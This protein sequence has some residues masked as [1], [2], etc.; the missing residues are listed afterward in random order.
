MGFFD[1][2]GKINPIKGAILGGGGKSHRPGKKWI[3]KQENRAR[4]EELTA[5][6]KDYGLIP[7]RLKENYT[8]AAIKAGTYANTPEF[9]Q[10]L[11]SEVQAGARGARF[12]AEARINSLRKAMGNEEVWKPEE[13]GQTAGNMTKDQLV[14]DN[15]PDKPVVDDA[16]APVAT[17]GPEAPAPTRVSKTNLSTAFNSRL[18]A[19]RNR[20]G[21][22][23]PAR[24]TSIKL[25]P[26]QS[27]E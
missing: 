25:N 18:S 13:S 24:Q 8:N 19:L 14:D 6:E 16:P 22:R 12:E 2:I 27:I 4:Q 21:S 10:G 5:A 7:D 15:V 23:T 1:V 9:A 17:A 20:V 26:R 3:E 11:D